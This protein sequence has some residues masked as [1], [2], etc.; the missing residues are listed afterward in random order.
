MKRLL[1]VF[2]LKGMTILLLV[3]AA[4][5]LVR[6]GVLYSMTKP[7]TRPSTVPTRS[8][9]SSRVAKPAAV[10]PAE[11]GG[12]FSG[13]LSKATSL[14]KSPIGQQLM[15]GAMG[16]AASK[17]AGGAGAGNITAAVE[18]AV[19][20]AVNRLMG[21]VNSK[22]AGLDQRLAV[23]EEQ[24]QGGAAPQGDFDGGYEEGS[25]AISVDDVE[26]EVSE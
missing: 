18:K 22:I 1:Q 19:G 12:F 17:V 13:L 25:E 11:S 20:P 15:S 16:F 5:V 9:T 10:K 24:L 3:V 4:G 2:S 6:Q 7:T 8:T 14:A 26:V 23:L 21:P